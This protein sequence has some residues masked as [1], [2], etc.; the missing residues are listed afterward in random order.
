MTVIFSSAVGLANPVTVQVINQGPGIWGNVATGLITAGAAIVAVMLTHRFTLRREKQASE[1]N[2]WREEHFIA[3]ELVFMLERFAEECARVA[4]DDGELV[5]PA[6]GKQCER[7]P[8]VEEP[9][10]NLDGITGDWRVLDPLLMFRIRELPVLQGEANRMI[11]YAG[12]NDDSPPDYSEY[13]HERQYQY[14]RLGLKAA[15]QA[16]RLCRLSGLPDTRLNATQWSAQPVLWEV[17]RIARH[18]I[19][20]EAIDNRDFRDAEFEDMAP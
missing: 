12:E 15:I 10:I 18:R 6:P 3:T 13:F 19:A 17:W 9:K 5:P 20:K 2:R 8:T 11:R 1:E 14:A 7:E 16:K 4:M